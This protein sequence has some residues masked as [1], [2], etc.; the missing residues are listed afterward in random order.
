MPK[1]WQL[2]PM[3]TRCCCPGK[4]PSQLPGSNRANHTRVSPICNVHHG[5]LTISAISALDKRCS[6]VSYPVERPLF[7][8]DIRDV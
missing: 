3:T 8:L 4:S 1:P 2:P 7:T 5:S 6:L